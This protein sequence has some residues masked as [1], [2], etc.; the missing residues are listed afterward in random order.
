MSLRSKLQKKPKC[1][2]LERLNVVLATSGS[3]DFLAVALATGWVQGVALEH[4]RVHV[5]GKDQ[6]VGITKEVD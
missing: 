4:S 1:A 5:R 3:Q 2:Y 6:R